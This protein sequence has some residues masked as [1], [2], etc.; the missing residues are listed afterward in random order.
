MEKQDLKQK[1]LKQ[2]NKKDIPDLTFLYSDEVLDI[3]LEFLEELLEQEKNIFKKLLKTEN[4]NISFDSFEKDTKLAYFWSLLNHLQSVNSGEKIEKIINDFEPKYIDFWNEVAY[5]KDYYNKII[6]CLEN[7]FLDIEQKRILS[8]RIK[9]FKLRWIDLEKE[10]QDKLKEISKKVAKLSQDFTNNIVKDK[11]NWEYLIKNFEDIKDL[12][13]ETLQKAEKLAIDKKLDWYLFIAD[14]T[15]MQDI[16]SYSTNDKI[17]KDFIL[18]SSNFA[19]K[20]EFDNRALILEILKLKKQKAEILW[21]KNFAEL[22]LVQKMADS[23]EQ[24]IDLIEWISKKAKQKAKKEILQLEKYFNTKIDQYN[25]AFYSRKHKQEKYNIDP[26]ELKKY[27]EFD[28]VLKYLHNFVKDFYGLELK[29]IDVSLYDEDVKAY[30][31]YK[32]WKLISYYLLDA[33]YRDTKRP[34]AWADNLREKDY[35]TWDL[36]LVIN[37][38]NFAKNKIWENILSMSDVETIF[39]EF[40]HAMHEMLSESKYSELSWFNVEWDFIELPS[41]IHENWVWESESLRKLAKH[42]KTWEVLSDEIIVKLD[43]LKRYMSWVWVARQNEFALL[44]MYLYKDEVPKNIEEL[45]KKFL[46]LVNKYWI[47]KRGEEYKMYTSFNH[48]FGWWYAA[49]YYSYMWAE[50]L[51]ADVFERI[52]EMW[53]FDRKIWEKFIKTILWQGSRKEAKEL[54]Y[55]FIWREVDNK[56]FMKRKWL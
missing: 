29:E 14:P 1:I 44:D 15:M 32:D 26:K 34:W 23:P 7:C 16:V 52:K 27:F 22:S 25:I 31:V 49:W 10:K 50:I 20:G 8:E 30:E 45:D 11:W 37:V 21:Y 38:C 4:K 42:Y 18:A 56:A 47:F 12:P 54:F 6:Y 19:S 2:L 9:N 33:F 28:N 51:E 35:L 40:G 24:I 55:D 36:P 48:I 41:Q 43:K 53:M 3:A 13:K 17:R 39:H 5:N 46:E